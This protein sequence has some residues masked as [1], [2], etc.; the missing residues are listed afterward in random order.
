ME[1]PSDD[2]P[3]DGCIIG[4]DWGERRIGLAVSDP[5]QN[6]AQPLATI[7]R[8]LGKRFPMKQLREVVEQRRPVGFVVGLPLTAEGGEG[9]AAEAA[10][11]MGH[12][13]KTKTSL[14]VVFRDERMTTA[15]A[16]TTVKE[17]GGRT[18]GRKGEID[19]LAATLL[20]QAF[21]DSRR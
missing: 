6:I 21:L 13:I 15:R 18:K 14:S 19:Q 16:L 3:L 12:L 11:Q 4:V 7:S 9:G 8:R 10:R 5:S 2:I 1:R 17:M 20:L